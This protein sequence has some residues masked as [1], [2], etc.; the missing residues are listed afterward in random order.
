MWY[1]CNIIIYGTVEVFKGH[2][3]NYNVLPS[4]LHPKLLAGIQSALQ[5]RH[6]SKS[7]A[8]INFP[9]CPHAASFALL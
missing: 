1:G 8:S 2:F 9:T 4:S 6:S 3:D 5:L 7:L